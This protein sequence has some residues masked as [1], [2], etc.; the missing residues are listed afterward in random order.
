M[1]C[2]RFYVDADFKQGAIVFLDGAELH[3][4]A[5]VIRVGVNDEVE[6][7][8]GKG[9]LAIARLANLAK[10]KAALEILSFLQVPIAPPRLILGLPLMRPSKL[11]WI[12]EKGVE[13]GADAFWLYLA[14]YS[15]KGDLS[16]HQSERL[17]TIAVSAM[18][19][20]GRLD[21]PP[22]LLLGGLDEFFASRGIWLFGDTREE[23]PSLFK[24]GIEGLFADGPI[25][26]ISGPE[27]GFTQRELNLLEIKARGIRLHSNILRAETAPLA[28]LSL[29]WHFSHHSQ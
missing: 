20:C 4:L 3:H 6:L 28:A 21:L 2:E 18:K 29:L 8:N 16:P 23:A 22:T 7:V 5:H 17:K 19:Q 27:R 24:V 15:E 25:F 11:E 14:D 13:L 26:F 9:A 1:P 12:I 10:Q